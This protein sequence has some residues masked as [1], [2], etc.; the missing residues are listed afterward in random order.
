M[1]DQYKQFSGTS[2]DGVIAVDP[3]ALAQLLG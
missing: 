3:I 1:A 2:V